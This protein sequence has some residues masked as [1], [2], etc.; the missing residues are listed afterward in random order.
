MDFQFIAEIFPVLLERLP[1][2][3]H[4][5]LISSIL[6]IIWAI[7]VAFLEIK[8]I[9]II[10]QFV[11]AYTSFMRS[12]PGII[13]LFLV[14]YGLP[15]LLEPLG[16]DLANV[17]RSFYAIVAL[18]LYN[19]AYMSEIFR[20]AYL[21][22]PSSQKEAGQ[23]IGMTEAQINIHILIPQVIPIVLPSLGNALIDLLKDTSILFIIGIVDIMGQA[24]II[25]TNNYGLYQAEVYFAIALIYWA[26]TL[27]LSFI[28]SAIAKRTA[29]YRVGGTS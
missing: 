3:L 29:K 20:P 7:F 18:V 8:E 22:L 28:Q 15:V 2:T 6:S 14:Y 27:L 23:S 10:K 4:I 17:Q 25:I 21:S 26:L 19:G 12:T 16:I 5:F 11:K 1:I 9:P 24:D 13:H